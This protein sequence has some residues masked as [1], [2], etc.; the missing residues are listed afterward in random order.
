MPVDNFEGF[1]K[2]VAVSSLQ[3]SRVWIGASLEERLRALGSP[4]HDFFIEGHRSIRF[5]A[6]E[7]RALLGGSTDGLCA[8]FADGGAHHRTTEGARLHRKAAGVRT[9]EWR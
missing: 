6:G 1:L 5:A 7:V 9:D 8:G 2:R 4:C 3:P